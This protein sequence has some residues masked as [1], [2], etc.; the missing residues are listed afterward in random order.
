LELKLHQLE[1]R[2]CCEHAQEFHHDR[3]HQLSEL[4][5]IQQ[6]FHHD[7]PVQGQC[8]QGSAL[9]DRE[10]LLLEELVRSFHQ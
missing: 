4:E 1:H 10:Q 2:L 5:Q 8:A 9:A 3:A 6:L 7:V